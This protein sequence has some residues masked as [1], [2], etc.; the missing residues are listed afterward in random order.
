MELGQIFTA[1]PGDACKFDL[2]K[3]RKLA[4]G[5]IER[6]YLKGHDWALEKKAG[7]EPFS[8]LFSCMFS[9]IA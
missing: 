7:L 3:N 4:Y 2:P 6:G 1:Q 8:E 5:V 9:E